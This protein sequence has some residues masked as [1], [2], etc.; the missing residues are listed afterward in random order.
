[1]EHGADSLEPNRCRLGA[2][3]ARLQDDLPRRGE[4]CLDNLSHR[5]PHG[6]GG[7]GND[8]SSTLKIRCRPNHVGLNDE[9]G[10]IGR[11]F[12]VPQ[13]A[14][15]DVT[16]PSTRI[17]CSIR[18]SKSCTFLKP[19]THPFALITHLLARV[20]LYH[21]FF[22]YCTGTGIKYRATAPHATQTNTQ[23]TNESNTM[24]HGLCSMA[25]CCNLCTIREVAA[26][27]EGLL[28]RRL[29]TIR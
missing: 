6:L 22:S 24:S 26:G 19:A 5:K 9:L 12:V 18:L 28:C 14:S 2:V 1:M 8:E 20:R 10:F 27:V 29:R 23:T 4:T 15:P 21:Q 7:T 25:W 17:G 3:D 16:A 13:R 11:W